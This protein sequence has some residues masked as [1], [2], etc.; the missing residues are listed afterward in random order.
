MYEPVITLE[1]QYLL[2]DEAFHCK[3]IYVHTQP[4]KI[5]S[6]CKD[7]PKKR[8]GNKKTENGKGSVMPSVQKITLS[9]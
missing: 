3:I 4:K 9:F 5:S 1:K 7:W 6:I 8:S 2:E